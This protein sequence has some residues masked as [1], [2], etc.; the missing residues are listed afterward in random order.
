MRRRQRIGRRFWNLRGGIW[1]RRSE[2][3]G[4]CVF[5]W[6]CFFDVRIFMGKVDPRVDAYI[7]KSAEFARPVLERIR[8]DVHAACPG[9][10]ETLKWGMPTFLHKGILCMMAAFKA[11]CT[12]GFWHPMM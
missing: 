11:H 12:F 4:A 10:E 3:C 2:A 6:E 7:A 1:G 5:E 9:V 8:T